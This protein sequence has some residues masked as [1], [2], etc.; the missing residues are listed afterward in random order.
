MSAGA[1]RRRPLVAIDGPG[2]AGKSTVSRALAHRLGVPRL[3]TGAMYRAVTWQALRSG[4]APE[5]AE[6][7]AAIAESTDIA[8]EEPE[9]VLADGEDV[10]TAIRTPEVDA[11]VSAVA[12]NPAVR[13]ALVKR[14]QAWIAGHDGAVVEG[15]DIGAVVVA[16]SRPQGV[17]DGKLA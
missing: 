10:T 9:R 11:A 4:V 5:D 8:F 7:T 17:L 13:Q 6:A 16:T 3:D 12:A 14:Q 1:T 15:R 2:G